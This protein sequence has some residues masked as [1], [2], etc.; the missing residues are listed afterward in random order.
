MDSFLFKISKDEYD[1]NLTKDHSEAAEDLGQLRSQKKRKAEQQALELQAR[2]RKNKQQQRERSKQAE[3]NTGKRTND[4]KLIRKRPTILQDPDTRHSALNMAVLTRPSSVQKR[5]PVRAQKKQQYTNWFCKTI[6]PDIQEAATRHN[7]SSSMIAKDLS[8]R[9]PK[10]FSKLTKGT[11]QYWI[12]STAVPRRWTQR[13][14][15][16][17]EQGS[18]WSPGEGRIRIL[19]DSGYIELKGSFIEALRGIYPQLSS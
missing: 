12:D 11:V 18:G 17:V 13:T 6:W 15:E 10:R 16:K 8:F 4:G 14:E 3:I 5:R 9:D 19:D 7:Y 2:K 1:F